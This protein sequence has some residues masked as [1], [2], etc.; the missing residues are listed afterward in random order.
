MRSF[1]VAKIW[2]EETASFWNLIILVSCVFSQK[3]PRFSATSRR[4]TEEFSLSLYQF[5]QREYMCVARGIPRFFVSFYK[6]RKGGFY[7][8]SHKNQRFL[9]HKKFMISSCFSKRTY[10]VRKLQK[11]KYLYITIDKYYWGR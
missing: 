2:V 4:E 8:G 11:N 10:E 9:G 6:K 7:F 1:C 3:R 5:D